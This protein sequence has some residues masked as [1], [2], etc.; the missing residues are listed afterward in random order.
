MERLG[1]FDA[2]HSRLVPR[3][4]PSHCGNRRLIRQSRPPLRLTWS[5]ADHPSGF[6]HI[7]STAEITIFADNV[8]EVPADLSGEILFGQLEPAGER[9]APP[10]GT[11]CR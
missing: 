7:Q 6:Y 9:G 1:I 2:V 3:A 8:S 5:P 4:G 11:L 10:A